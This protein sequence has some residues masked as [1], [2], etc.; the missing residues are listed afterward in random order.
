MLVSC[1]VLQQFQ[2]KHVLVDMAPDKSALHLLPSH[3]DH[4]II[5]AKSAAEGYLDG[6][7]SLHGCQERFL[8]KHAGYCTKYHV[9][10]NFGMSIALTAATT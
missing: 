10:V 4:S 3:Y 1:L 6:S 5:V 7:P 8:H 2:V 9:H